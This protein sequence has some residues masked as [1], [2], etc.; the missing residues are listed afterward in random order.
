MQG[1]VWGRFPQR[2]VE[3]LRVLPGPEAPF[4]VLSGSRSLLRG[5]SSCCPADSALRLL[6]YWV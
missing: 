4:G 1:V 3:T 5:T 6:A 2:P